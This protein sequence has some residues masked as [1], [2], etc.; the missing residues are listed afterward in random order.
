LFRPEIIPRKNL[1]H[2][3]P[4]DVGDTKIADHW[5]DVGLQ[6]GQELRRVPLALPLRRML[7]VVQVNHLRERLGLVGALGA[8]DSNSCSDR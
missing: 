7:P 2:M 6:C 1:Q 4:A 3:I 5:I 8:V